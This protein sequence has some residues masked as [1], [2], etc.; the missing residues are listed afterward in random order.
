MTPPLA[1]LSPEQRD[2]VRSGTSSDD[3]RC[4][5]LN[6]DAAK[7]VLPAFGYLVYCSDPNG[8][9]ADVCKAMDAKHT[10]RKMKTSERLA[11]EIASLL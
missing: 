9:L 7:A 6:E 4:L 2:G 10:L 5:S 3:C 11:N 8:E 1:P